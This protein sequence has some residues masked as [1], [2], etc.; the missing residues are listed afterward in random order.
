MKTA[1]DDWLICKCPQYGAT[2]AVAA[3][4]TQSVDC[5]CSHLLHTVKYCKYRHDNKSHFHNNEVCPAILL[6]NSRKPRNFLAWTSGSVET[7]HVYWLSLVTSGP[8]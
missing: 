5:S 1:F 3:A 4:K 7:I 2:D 8:G 6:F